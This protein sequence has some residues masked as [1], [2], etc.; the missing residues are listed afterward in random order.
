MKR[1]IPAENIHELF[2]LTIL[3]ITTML[4]KLKIVNKGKKWTLNSNSHRRIDI[5]WCVVESASFVSLSDK[6]IHWFP[7]VLN[8]STSLNYLFET[9]N[10]KYIG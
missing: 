10:N 5:R 2:L 1:N 4:Q 6:I 3:I 9:A 7:G 8:K